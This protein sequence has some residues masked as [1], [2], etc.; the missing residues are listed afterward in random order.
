MTACY[1][2]PYPYQLT[3]IEYSLES[4]NCSIISIGGWDTFFFWLLSRSEKSLYDLVK[5]VVNS[6][7]L[8]RFLIGGFSSWGTFVT[9]L[10]KLTAGERELVVC[11]VS[12]IET[13]TVIWF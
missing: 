7:D 2:F 13:D 8:L 9:V 3:V 10:S 5:V 4:I 12:A 11:D 1:Q 6:I